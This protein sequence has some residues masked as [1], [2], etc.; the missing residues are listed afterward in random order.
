MSEL[1]NTA[2]TFTYDPLI[3]GP[4]PAR[5]TK[6]VTII[7]GAGV[8]ARGTVLGK[9]NASGKYT[10]VKSTNTDGSQTA[11][12]VLAQAI[13]ATNAD[14]IA[15]VYLRGRFN[16]SA[17]IFGGTDTADTH[18]DTLRDLDIYLTNVQ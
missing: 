11:N 5:L 13:D 18:E 9:I 16:R 4:I 17:L 12:C 10:I 15:T 6:N 14:V 7:S 3:G 8:L 2:A 1:V